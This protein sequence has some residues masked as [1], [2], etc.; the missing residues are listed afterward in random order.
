MDLQTLIVLLTSAVSGGG[1][2]KIWDVFF[3]NR[4]YKEDSETSYR[5]ELK[6]DVDQL[7]KDLSEI[8]AELIQ[9]NKNYINLLRDYGKLE[10]LFEGIKQENEML[11]KVVHTLEQKIKDLNNK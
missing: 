4:K 1:L 11:K 7:R 3:N 5:K 8:Q 2:Y 10:I 9:S 6:E